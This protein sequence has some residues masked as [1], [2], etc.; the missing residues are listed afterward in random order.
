MRETLQ[1]D[2]T[3]TIPQ[4]KPLSPGEVLGCTAPKLGEADAIMYVGKGTCFNDVHINLPCDSYL[5]DGRF[6][7]E[8]IMVHN[9]QVPAF[10]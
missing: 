6:H 10:Q 9:P 3:V 7:L 5:G 4:I 1:Q 2:Y 8:S